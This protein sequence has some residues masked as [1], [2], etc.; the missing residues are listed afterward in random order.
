M[1]TI[2]PKKRSVE[3]PQKQVKRK[4]ERVKT[5]ML[6]YYTLSVFLVVFIVGTCFMYLSAFN[7]ISSQG[8]FINQLER[9]RS[10]LIIE[11]EVWNMRIAKLKSMDVIQEQDVVYR[12]PNVDPA[13]I[14]FINLDTRKE[15]EEL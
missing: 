15:L 13:E 11:N 7:E 4:R 9:A 1:A 3:L 2:N 5:I 10:E 8:V 6:N 12:M 14:E